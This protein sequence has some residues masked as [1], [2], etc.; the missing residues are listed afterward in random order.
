MDGA[1]QRGADQHPEQAGEVAELRGQD[2]ADQRP[3]AGDRGEVMPEHHPPMGR[4]E[5]LPVGVGL[6]RRLPQFVDD[7]VLAGHGRQRVGIWS[8]DG[9]T[10]D[11]APAMMR[12]MRARA[13]ANASQ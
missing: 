12:S 8:G 7:P 5:V 4:D 9:P 1:P 6:R 10:K 11:D 3:G 13:Q 2:G